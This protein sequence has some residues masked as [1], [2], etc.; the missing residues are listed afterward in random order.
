MSAD[1]KLLFDEAV[2]ANQDARDFRRRLAARLDEIREQRS[3]P[4]DLLPRYT[5]YVSM[6]RDEAISFQEKGVDTLLT[7]EMMEACLRDSFDVAILFAADEDYVPLVD[8]V[9]RDGRRV[10]HAFLDVANHGRR[11]RQACD[12]FRVITELDLHRLGKNNGS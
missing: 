3:V 4:I 7:V 6:L 1:D 9:K 11:L 2:R 5:E 12:D 8:A 10:V